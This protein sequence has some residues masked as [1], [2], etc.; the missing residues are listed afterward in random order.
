MEFLGSLVFL[1]V[2]LVF[3]GYLYPTLGN[4][5]IVPRSRWYSIDYTGSILDSLVIP[6]RFL[7]IL[8]LLNS[9]SVAYCYL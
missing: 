7:G 5:L 9:V 4:Y 1:G 3:L 6:N 8:L 2:R